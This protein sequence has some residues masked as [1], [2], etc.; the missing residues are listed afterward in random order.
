MIYPIQCHS[1]EKIYILFP[2]EFGIKMYPNAVNKIGK[3]IEQCLNL[4]ADQRKKIF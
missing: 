1:Q 3:L 4:D 2:A